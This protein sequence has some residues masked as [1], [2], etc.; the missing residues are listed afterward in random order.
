VLE[1]EPLVVVSLKRLLSV[2]VPDTV[3]VEVILP[4]V[5]AV[6]VVV[7]KGVNKNGL[8]FK[9]ISPNK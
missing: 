6:V 4:V 7:V 5:V 3:V 9:K 1:V 2:V 8:S